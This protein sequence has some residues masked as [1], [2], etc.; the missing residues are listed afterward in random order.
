MKVKPMQVM[1]MKD[2][3][4]QATPTQVNFQA[5][6][7]ELDKNI[8]EWIQDCIDLLI[9]LYKQTKMAVKKGQKL[10][11]ILQNKISLTKNVL[12]N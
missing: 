2:M 11:I 9:R 4:N 8:S 6:S 5:A 10:D 3:L 12:L 7:T 1:P